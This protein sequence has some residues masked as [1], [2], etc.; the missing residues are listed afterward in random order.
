MSD[1]IYAGASVQVYPQDAPLSH[2]HACVNGFLDYVAKFNTINFHAKDDDVREWR[3]DKEYDNWQDRLGMDSV[4][5]FYHYAHSTTM[6]DGVFLTAMGRTWDDTIYAWSDRMSFGD[7]RLRYLFLHG[8]ESLRMHDGH[9]PFRTWHTPNLGA[10]MLFGFDSLT[11][12]TDQQGTRFFKEWNTG[13]SFSQAWQDAALSIFHNDHR[14]SSAACGATDRE[15]QDRLWNERLFFGEPVSDNW[16]W[17]R[18][19]GQV[20]IEVDLGLHVPRR[21]RALRLSRRRADADTAAELAERFGLRAVLAE[22]ASPTAEEYSAPVEFE[23]RLVMHP[24]GAYHVFYAEP[25]RTADSIAPQEVRDIADRAIRQLDLGHDL[26]LAGMSATFHGGGSRDGDEVAASVAEYTLHYRQ[27]YDGV[28]AVAGGDGQLSVTLDPAGRLCSI[29]DTTVPIAGADETRPPSGDDF[30]AMAALDA[31][32][33]ARAECLRDGARSSVVPDSL[34]V[35]YRFDRDAAIVV[36]RQAVE[37]TS[38]DRFRIR[39][40]VEITV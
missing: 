33:S 27:V 6:D 1:N 16:Y 35:G 30:D 21:P 32:T 3:Y 20:P 37:I 13:K 19:A 23:P 29:S 12:D 38:S 18:W 22:P 4:K 8:C 34:E 7:Q 40:V 31:A 14:V 11:F 39:D 17:W 10:R 2:P 15:A 28:A 36:A 26:A 24:D 9:S 5:V 25:D